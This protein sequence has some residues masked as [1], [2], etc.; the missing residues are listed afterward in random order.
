MGIFGVGVILPA[1]PSEPGPPSLLSQSIVFFSF[2]MLRT[3]EGTESV[4]YSFLICL[5]PR[6]VW[7]TGL[8][9]AQDYVHSVTAVSQC[10]A[11]CLACSSTQEIVE[12]KREALGSAASESQVERWSSAVQDARAAV[13]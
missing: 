12:I 7:Y 9:S 3:M 10:L 4:I 2:V 11:E 6:S 13:W 1:T 5:P 8:Y